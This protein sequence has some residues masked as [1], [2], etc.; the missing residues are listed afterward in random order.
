MHAH[1][2]GAIAPGTNHFH[3]HAGV[4]SHPCH[5][6]TQL[7]PPLN[8]GHFTALPGPDIAKRQGR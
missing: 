6:G 4:D 3:F 1:H 8:S 7:T 2:A 5:S